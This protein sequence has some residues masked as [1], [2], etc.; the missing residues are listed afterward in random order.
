MS[1]DEWGER[2]G[3]CG[4][5]ESWGRG[6]GRPRGSTPFPPYPNS[7][8]DDPAASS[9][10]P[11]PTGRAGPWRPVTGRHG[12]PHPPVAPAPPP[13]A[14]AAATGEPPTTAADD[15]DDASR[16]ARLAKRKQSNRES[17]RRSRQRRQADLESLAARVADLEAALAV[18]TEERDSAR[19]ALRAALATAGG[20]AG[21]GQED[22]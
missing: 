14:A 20:E 13:R 17:A 1:D 18:V 19:R 2:G 9:A 3:Q 22:A 15:D 12:A 21:R 10:L 11:R 5:E 6:G 8:D 7:Q 16:E 4:G